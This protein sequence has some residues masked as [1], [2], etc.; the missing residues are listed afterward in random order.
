MS[1]QKPSF[2]IEM[3]RFDFDTG[4]KVVKAKHKGSFESF[5]KASPHFPEEAEA[6]LREAW[7]KS[8]EITVTEALSIQN[9][10]SRRLCFKYI[11]IEKI[12]NELKPE[13]V[14]DQT[15]EKSTRVNKEGKLESF[16]DRYQ[17]YK[18]KG[19]KLTGDTDRS[20]RRA[21]D[22][23]ILRCKCTSTDREYLIYVPEIW[24]SRNSFG[25]ER[26][27]VSKPDA[28]DA[29][30]WT[31]QVELPAG[32]ID[33]IIRAGDCIMVKPKSEKYEK[34]QLRH[35][36]KKEYLEKVVMES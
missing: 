3:C 1:D 24:D 32:Q 17:L 29:V 22:F 8:G 9:L 35:L 2:R 16:M 18:V 4:I 28:I 33:K 10:E 5:L 12:F 19:E 30:A 31:I 7:D 26:R 34:C 14:D 23:Y 36:S 20:F 21:Q 6:M 25:R 11:G 13:L 15:I 27:S